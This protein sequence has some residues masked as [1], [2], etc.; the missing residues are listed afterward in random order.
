MT[1]WFGV[2]VGVAVA[3]VAAAASP[4]TAQLTRPQIAS[5]LRAG[6]NPGC[7]W[8][9]APAKDVK[10]CDAKKVCRTQIIPAQRIWACGT[11]RH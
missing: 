8:V 5:P 11:V 6:T 3:A 9:E 10:V 4:A 2:A 7:R 1:R